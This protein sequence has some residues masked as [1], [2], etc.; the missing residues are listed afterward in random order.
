MDGQNGEKR[1]RLLIL[2][3][4]AL[5]RT[6]LARLLALEN[7]FEVV[8]ECDTCAAALNALHA[9]SVDVVLLDFIFANTTDFIPTARSGGYK[10]QFPPF[11]TDQ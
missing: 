10:G 7:G 2:D 1:I 6:S 8:A 5:F 3:D 9:S 11:R 4:Q